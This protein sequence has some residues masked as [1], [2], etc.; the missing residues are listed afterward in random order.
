MLSLSTGTLSSLQNIQANAPGTLWHAIN[1]LLKPFGMGDESYIEPVVT[2]VPS[3]K[4]DTYFNRPATRATD[5]Q[6]F[7][8]P[9]TDYVEIR[10]DWFASD[11]KGPF[12]LSFVDATGSIL[13]K[14]EVAS[15]QNNIAVLDVSKLPSGLFMIHIID[16]D[17]NA[18][19]TQKL[20][21]VR[22]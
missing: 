21:I 10:W 17:G 16:E 7:P 6:I 1:N 22:D 13:L 5:F 18:L 15:W 14:Q 2:T 4:R 8:N 20:T 19:E 12:E 3:N 9:A 11:L